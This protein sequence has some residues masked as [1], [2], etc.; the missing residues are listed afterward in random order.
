MATAHVGGPRHDDRVSDQVLDPADADLDEVAARH[1]WEEL[2][3]EIRDHQFAYYVRDAPTV[4]DGEYDRLLRRLEAL[5]DRYAEYG[6][7]T[8][9]SPTQRVGGTFS[10]EF[11]AVEH[12]ERMLSLDNAFSAED[13]AT[14]FDRVQRDLDGS[15]AGLHLLCELKIDGLAISL[16]YEKG[17]LT[18]GLTRGDGRTGED[19]TLNVRT[20]EGIPHRLAGE[21]H[22]DLIEIRGEVF[23]P[24]EGFRAVNEAQVAA[25]RPPFANPRN[26]AAGSLRQKDPRVTASRP[27]RAYCHGIGALRWPGRTDVIARQS[28]AYD[29]LAGWGLPVSPHSRVVSTLAEVQAMIDHYGE[30]RHDVEHEI[31]GIVVK[32]DEVAL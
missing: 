29:L 20:I 5:E 9:D 12:V 14:W 11:A 24:V 13:L 27:L 32:V 31:D 2:A 3:R 21:N 30:H 4:S 8:P 7:R 19:V 26:T 22:P 6:L 1:R 23:L 17:V 15:S 25:G 16:V 28:E 18:R 10:T